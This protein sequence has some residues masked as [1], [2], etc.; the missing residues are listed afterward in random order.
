MVVALSLGSYWSHYFPYEDDF[1]LI[2]Y[3][4]A[5][6]SPAPLTWISAGFSQYFANDPNCVTGNFGMVRPVANITHYME[7]L[8]YS[9]ADGPF[10]MLTNVLCWILSS[11]LVYGIARRLGASQWIA[12]AGL[13]LY[14]LSPCWYRVL[15]HSS[16][17]TNGLATCWVLAAFYVLLRKN[18]LGYKH[19]LLSGGFVA[20]AVGS[21]EQAIMSIPI[22]VFTV[23]WLCLRAENVR[24]PRRAAISIALLLAP[25]LLMAAC[26]KLTNQKYGVSYASTGFLDSLARSDRLAALGIHSSLL[27]SA[28]KLPG[29]LLGALIGTLHAYTPMGADNMA[30]PNTYVGVCLFV[31][32]A[33]SVLLGRKHSSM[34]NFPAVVFLLYGFGRSL[35][36]PSPDPRFM[37]MEVAWG[38]IVLVC[39]LSAGLASRTR[40]AI[41]AAALAAI[42]L[43]AFEAVS[44][45]Y[46]II[47]RRAELIRREEV[48][49]EAFR[50]IRTAAQEYPQA[51]VVLVNDQQALWSARAMLQLAGFKGDDFEILPTIHNWP[52]TDVLG[53]FT[54]CPVNVSMRSLPVTLQIRVDYP[55]G[56]SASTFGRDLNCTVEHYRADPRPH[57]LAWA[58][59]LLQTNN[60]GPCQPPLVHD[61]PL[62]PAN[63]LVI[64]A[65]HQRLLAPV[66]KTF[67]DEANTTFARE[68]DL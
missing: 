12:S 5:E 10:L 41:V 15:I 49:R 7:S 31:L 62:E 39:A 8:F 18:P 13:I 20:L 33:G 51:R 6:N 52:S 47:A 57:A 55:V 37:Q 24:W 3:S 65:W 63:P 43:L 58:Q 59:C 61:V 9:S 45:N 44:F 2:R 25:A 22:L 53:D 16:F 29:K 54:S 28:I 38:I 60:Q 46:T 17:R 11:C 66:T 36:M 19:V 67:A 50:R 68:T 35:V 21:H 14:A 27:I 40:S 48:D 64:I 23:G 30:P 32:V 56:C 26:F 4:G 34:T 1:S 42:G